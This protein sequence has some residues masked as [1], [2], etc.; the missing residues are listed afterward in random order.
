MCSHFLVHYEMGAGMPVPLE[1]SYRLNAA[2]YITFALSVRCFKSTN[3]VAPYSA[4]CIATVGD[5]YYSTFRGRHFK[6]SFPRSSASVYNRRIRV[7][8][9]L[10]EPRDFLTNGTVAANF[11]RGSLFLLP[12]FHLTILVM[13]CAMLLDGLVKLCCID[14]LW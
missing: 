12:L 11:I 9:Y 8:R 14:F 1:A 2:E 6:A 3:S 10:V 4:E 13:C 7:G 5:R